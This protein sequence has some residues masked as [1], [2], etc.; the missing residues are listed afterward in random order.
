M[1]Q[2]ILFQGYNPLSIT[3]GMTPFKISVNILFPANSSCGLH[4]IKQKV[5]SRNMMWRCAFYFE[6]RDHQKAAKLC[7]LKISINVLFLT[8]SCNLYS[9]KVKLGLLL[10]HDVESIYCFEVTVHKIL[11][12]MPL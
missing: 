7:P 1:E 5:N 8:N 4:D 6:V 2:G 9:I 3:R 11:A 10:D 12:V